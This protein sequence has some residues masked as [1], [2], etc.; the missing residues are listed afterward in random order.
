MA[1]LDRTTTQTRQPNKQQRRGA[2]KRARLGPS[3][4]S[5]HIF[6]GGHTSLNADKGA[7]TCTRRLLQTDTIFPLGFN[8]ETKH[9]ARNVR[10]HWKRKKQVA[11]ASRLRVGA[12]PNEANVNVSR[13]CCMHNDTL[14]LSV[15]WSLLAPFPF[16][17]F[18]SQSKWI[19]ETRP[20]FMACPS[21]GLFTFRPKNISQFHQKSTT[22]VRIRP[23]IDQNLTKNRPKIKIR[24]KNFRIRTKFDQKSEF[25]QNL[26][27]IRPINFR[28]RPKKRIKNQNWTKIRKFNNPKCDIWRTWAEFIVCTMN[29]ILGLFACPIFIFSFFEQV[30]MYLQD[31]TIIYGLRLLRR[32]HF[33]LC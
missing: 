28:V 20:L 8:W 17:S 18:S 32:V 21:Y 19:Y 3:C 16:S 26:T 22:K 27:K 29:D 7:V 1:R 6:N 31:Q 13:I 23:N 5:T 4:D 11:K 10:G 15:S 25:D 2:S 24:P 12:H 14:G 33:P 30:K 9:K